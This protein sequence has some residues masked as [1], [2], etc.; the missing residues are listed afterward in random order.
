MDRVPESTSGIIVGG[1]DSLHRFAPV[2]GA[3]DEGGR[4]RPGTG[5][6][7]PTVPAAEVSEVLVAAQ[8]TQRG[9]T[10]QRR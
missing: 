8:P 10:P 5:M 7:G 3:G 4:P 1:Q 6:P 2:T 9:G